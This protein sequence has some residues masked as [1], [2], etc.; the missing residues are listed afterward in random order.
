MRRTPEE[1]ADLAK[2]E[3]D[4]A[5]PQ[6]ERKVIP[7]PGYALNAHRSIKPEYFIAIGICTH[8][9]CSP[10]DKFTPGPQPLLP[11]NWVGGYCVL[12]MVPRSI[13]RAWCLKTSR[14]PITW[15]RPITTCLR[16]W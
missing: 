15:N 3:G 12:A 1:L 14:R 5:D 11:D 16:P 7:T 2:V 8:L 9:G 6:S 13:W 10:G 4:L